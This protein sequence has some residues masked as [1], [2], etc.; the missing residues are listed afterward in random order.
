MAVF[1]E[2]NKENSAYV[3]II[4]EYFDKLNKY[5]QICLRFGVP[6]RQF[7]PTVSVS[8]QFALGPQYLLEFLLNKPNQMFL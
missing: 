7:L 5:T 1:C 4:R 6:R 2:H 8:L 3:K